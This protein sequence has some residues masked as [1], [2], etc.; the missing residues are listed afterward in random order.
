MTYFVSVP[1]P[2]FSFRSDDFPPLRFADPRA[3][4]RGFEVTQ[5]LEQPSVSFSALDLW[6]SP[7]NVDM[8]LGDK[9]FVGLD[10]NGWMESAAW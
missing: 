9:T 5:G 7:P 4:F 10:C 1:T 8:M 3:L 2:A 6:K